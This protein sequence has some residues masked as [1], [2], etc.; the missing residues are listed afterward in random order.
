M[1]KRKLNLYAIGTHKPKVEGKQ[2][3]HHGGKHNVL[4]C[5]HRPPGYFGPF[6]VKDRECDPGSCSVETGRQAGPRKCLDASSIS[7]YRN[8]PASEL[9]TICQGRNLGHINL[10]YY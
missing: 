8:S 3:A 10:V 4:K 1:S 2:D 6:F 5:S 9:E 7:E